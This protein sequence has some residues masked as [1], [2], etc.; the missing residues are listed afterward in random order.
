MIAPKPEFDDY[1]ADYDGGSD[2]PLKRLLGTEH[3][4]MEWKLDWLGRRLQREVGPKPLNVLDF[5]CGTG[6]ALN[7]WSARRPQDSLAGVDA[8]EN[9]LREAARRWSGSRIPAFK[10]L[11]TG[12]SP[13]PNQ[14]FDLILMSCVL[15]HVAPDERNPLLLNIIGLLKPGGRLC[16]FEHNPRNFLV[17]YVVRNTK[18]DQNA[19]LLNAEETMDRLQT[20]G[21]SEVKASFI[22]FFPPALKMLATLEKGLAWLPLGGQYAVTG[23]RPRIEA[24]R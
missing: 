18:I 5:G 24:G 4:F 15:H 8:S 2:N 17:R 14:S 16:V 19:I 9:M 1:A 3:S 13:W 11:R 22:L 7:L 10:V 21:Y 23:F 20:T 6:L 12:E